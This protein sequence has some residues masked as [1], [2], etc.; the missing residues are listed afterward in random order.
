MRGIVLPAPFPQHSS[1]DCLVSREAAKPRSETQ[2]VGG[3]WASR[4][5]ESAGAALQCFWCCGVLGRVFPLT[6]DPSPPFHGG[7]GRISGQLSVMRR[8]ADGSPRVSKSVARAFQPEICPLRL[9]RGP[10][11][12]VRGPSF[13]VLVPVPVLDF[14]AFSGIVV[15]IQCRCVSVRGPAIHHTSQRQFC[16]YLRQ[17]SS[18][19]GT[20]VA[21]VMG[22]R[23]LSPPMP[24]PI[25]LGEPVEGGLGWVGEFPDPGRQCVWSV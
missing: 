3:Q 1:A 4:G 22:G 25:G 11:S 19:Q 17:A 15:P 9:V 6:P 5:R 7:E 14:F 23:P 18:R 24:F 21:A 10:W 8:A 20:V 13:V 12:V 2:R 16:A